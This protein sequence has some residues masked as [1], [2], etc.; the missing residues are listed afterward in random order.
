MDLQKPK[1]SRPEARNDQEESPKYRVN[2]YKSSMGAIDHDGNDPRQDP[3]RET[4]TVK[5]DANRNIPKPSKLQPHAPTPRLITLPVRRRIPQRVMAAR[6]PKGIVLDSRQSNR[7]RYADMMPPVTKETLS[8]LDLERIVQNIHLR[9]DANFEPELHFLPDLDGEKGRQKRIMADDYWEALS[10][11]IMI[12]TYANMNRSD[13]GE[14]EMVHVPDIVTVVKDDNLFRPRLPVMFETLHGILM[15]LVPDRDHASVSQNLD[16]SLLMQQVHKGVLDLVSLSNWLA[17]LLKTH[18]APM[19]DQLV[20]EMAAEIG[21]GSTHADAAKVISGLRKLFTILELMKL[22]VANHQ[23]GSFRIVLIEGTIP[24]LQDY[25]SRR[26]NSDKLKIEKVKSWYQAVRQRMSQPTKECAN[27]S[28]FPLSVLLHGLCELLLCSDPDEHVKFP[29]T[30]TFDL[31]RLWQLRSQVQNIIDVYVCWSILGS[32]IEGICPKYS[33]SPNMHS[34]FVMRIS[35]LME[36]DGE[37]PQTKTSDL[38][39][40]LPN[41]SCIA[42]EIAR[43]ICV[44]IGQADEVSDDIL[45]QV[46]ELMKKSFTNHSSV[47]LQLVRDCVHQQLLQATCEIAQR[48]LTMSPLEIC[49]SQR[50]QAYLQSPTSDFGFIATKLAHIGVLHWRV[51]APLVY[52]NEPSA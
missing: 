5:L 11:E 27:R 12:Y 1:K 7:L 25:F 48:Y 4:T 8:E 26:I 33:Y 10:I 30:F 3:E 50:R 37:N 28:F 17:N 51:W 9:M 19:R 16:V 38:G 6:I 43:T 34:S 14:I 40:R 52:T 2:G 39:T 49:E 46:E 32:L 31:R 20:D 35:A 22:D 41:D 21:S 24:F 36:E 18:C 13:A 47:Q 29:E 23:L 42:M 45:E 44:A 15:T